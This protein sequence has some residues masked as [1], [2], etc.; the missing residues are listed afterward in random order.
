MTQL[1]SCNAIFRRHHMGRLLGRMGALLPLWLNGPELTRECRDLEQLCW[2]DLGNA[3]QPIFDGDLPAFLMLGADGQPHSLSIPTAPAELAIRMDALGSSP[4]PVRSLISTNLDKLA[5]LLNF[6]PF[7]SQW[8]LWSYC[9]TRFGRAIL[10]VIPTRETTHGCEVLALLC[11]MPV[12]AVQ[13]AVASRRL[14]TW[15]FLDGISTD[16]EMPSLLSGWLSA[17]D[18]FADWIEQPYSSDSDLLTALCQA[19]V[20]LTAFR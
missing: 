15:G 6:T 3:Q 2:R 5:L 16:G 8:L 17:T 11:E 13:E 10:P 4:P 14:H 1:A 18:Q 19:Q 12:D 20:S 7:E 9:V